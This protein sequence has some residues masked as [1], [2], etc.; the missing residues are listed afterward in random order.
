M[1]AAVV[2]AVNDGVDIS[3]TLDVAVCQQRLREI[4]GLL[5]LPLHLNEDISHL[6]AEYP[7]CYF[8]LV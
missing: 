2:K 5:S 1:S 6:I 7:V 8:P 4:G 3:D